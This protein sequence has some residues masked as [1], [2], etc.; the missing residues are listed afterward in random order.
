MANDRYLRNKKGT[1]RTSVLKALVDRTAE[2][3][4]LQ[5][6]VVAVCSQLPP[7]GSGFILIASVYVTIQC[8][9]KAFELETFPE[10]KLLVPCA[11]TL[12]VLKV[13]P[14]LGNRLCKRKLML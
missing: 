4:Q 14:D 12:N 2:L 3:G 10:K 8:I 11:L 7:I 9:C 1:A 5:F 6:E 13:S